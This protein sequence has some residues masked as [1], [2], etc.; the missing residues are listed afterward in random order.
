PSGAWQGR[1]VTLPDGRWVGFG[2]IRLQPDNSDVLLFSQSLRSANYARAFD[3]L[4]RIYSNG[5]WAS[6]LAAL[7]PDEDFV[8][9]FQL[10]VLMNPGLRQ[11]AITSGKYSDS[12]VRNGNVAPLVQTKLQ[13][14]ARLYQPAKR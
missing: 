5:R 7:S 2:D 12:I 6:A 8:E 14:F 13:C 11:T 3:G 1:K 10:F 4:H 9:S